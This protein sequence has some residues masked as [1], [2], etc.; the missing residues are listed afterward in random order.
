[1][2]KNGFT[3][4]EILVVLGISIILATGGFLS[5]WNLKKH[6]ALRLAAESM[7]AFLRD[8]QSRSA[9]QEGGLG[10]GVHFENSA[11]RDSYW[12]FSGS[13]T[14]D[15]V[16]KVVLPAAVEYDMDTASD[17]VLFSKVSGLPDS[18]TTV[19]IKLLGDDDS[20][21]T[22]KINAQGTIE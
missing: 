17:E 20:V 4:I 5:L 10:W 18:A 19:K 13:A 22:I 11:D 12:L 9:T 21:I 7:V 1:M 14:D 6:Q 15:A 8:A 3:L 16:E 2:K